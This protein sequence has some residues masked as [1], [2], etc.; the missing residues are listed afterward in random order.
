MIWVAESFSPRKSQTPPIVTSGYRLI[1]GMTTEAFPPRFNAAKLVSAPRPFNRPPSAAKAISDKFR[2]RQ[3]KGITSA[4]TAETAQTATQNHTNDISKEMLF[5]L[6]FCVT[7]VIPKK[8]SVMTES[9]NEA[10]ISDTQKIYR[11]EGQHNPRDLR[12]ID[13][14]LKNGKSKNNSNKRRQANHRYDNGR[15]SPGQGQVESHVSEAAE[16]ACKQTESRTFFGVPGR[17]S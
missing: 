8:T 13:R 2:D 12:A 16:D 7:P 15:L 10:C 9:Q 17:L 5:V 3:S 4:I 6:N 1:I 14:F 11:R